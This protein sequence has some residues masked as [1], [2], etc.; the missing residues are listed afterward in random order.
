MT[1]TA[2]A[3]AVSRAATVVSALTHLLALPL[4]PLKYATRVN[5]NSSTTPKTTG[6]VSVMVS[7]QPTENSSF[8]ADPMRAVW[9][10]D[11]AKNG[12]PPPRCGGSQWQCAAHSS[13]C[14]V[15][16]ND[17]DRSPNTGGNCSIATGRQRLLRDIARHQR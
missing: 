4:P 8:V 12:R 7:C 1:T 3:A 2:M 16:V 5:V 6:N 15:T 10:T 9:S 13:C 11:L 17:K 14:H